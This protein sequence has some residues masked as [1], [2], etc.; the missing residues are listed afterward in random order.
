VSHL[1][2]WHDGTAVPG[3]SSRRE[4][5]FIAVNGSLVPSRCRRIPSRDKRQGP[6]AV[7]RERHSPR[8]GSA[9][10]G[11]SD[12]PTLVT[13][14]PPAPGHPNIRHVVPPAYLSQKLTQP[15][16][17]RT[18]R[19]NDAAAKMGNLRGLCPPRI[20]ARA[21]PRVSLEEVEYD[22]PH[23]ID[24]LRRHGP[25]HRLGQAPPFSNERQVRALPIL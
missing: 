14:R 3:R 21:L 25:I 22:L 8:P 13:A 4:G 5:K 17:P 24:Y 10:V 6:R 20:P 19:G 2:P 23:E 7:L 9:I 18:A 1:N 16:R 11:P 12:T 15:L